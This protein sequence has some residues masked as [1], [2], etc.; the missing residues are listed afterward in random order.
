VQVNAIREAAQVAFEQ[1]DVQLL[2]S[3]LPKA[4]TRQDQVP[5]MNLHQKRQHTKDLIIFFS[6]H[7]V[8]TGAGDGDVGQAGRLR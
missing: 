4:T 5:H 8:C 7:L 1:K 6:A 3:I 2:Q